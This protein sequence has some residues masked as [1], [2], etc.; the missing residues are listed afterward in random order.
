VAAAATPKM[1]PISAIA[2]N[3]DA[4]CFNG[5]KRLL[6]GGVLMNGRQRQRY[7]VI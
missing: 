1:V 6:K 7:L 5:F 3:N 2:G 4:M